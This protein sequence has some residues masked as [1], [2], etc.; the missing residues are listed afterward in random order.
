[1]LADAKDKSVVDDQ[2]CTLRLCDVKIVTLGVRCRVARCKGIRRI[3]S[4]VEERHRQS[5]SMRIILDGVL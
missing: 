5:Q 3:L 4:S 2:A 1:M